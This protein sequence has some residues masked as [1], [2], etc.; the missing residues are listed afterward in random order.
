MRYSIKYMKLASER[1]INEAKIFSFHRKKKD[2]IAAQN[3]Q[4]NRSAGMIAAVEILR[5]VPDYLRFFPMKGNFFENDRKRRSQKISASPDVG[6]CPGG[7]AV[8]LS[9]VIFFFFLFCLFLRHIIF[10]FIF[11]SSYLIF[12]FLVEFDV[13]PSSFFPS[14]LL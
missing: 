3:E 13:F 9:G 10:Y 4:Q 7:E 12:F 14:L 2:G 11:I 5:L 8:F 6:E 1:H